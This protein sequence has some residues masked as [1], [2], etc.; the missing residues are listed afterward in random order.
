M[1]GI[2]LV[3][4][5]LDLLRPLILRNLIDVTIPSGD[6]NR[7][8][9]LT[10]G[11]LLIP[12]A[13]GWI[14]VWQR[15]LNSQVGEG[16]IYDLR[17]ALYSRLQR[18][19]LRFFTHTRV[20]ELMSRLNN[21]VI[22]A[23]NAISNT[24]VDIIT[25]IIQ[26][27]AVLAVMFALEWRLTLI[28]IVILPL[29]ILAARCSVTRLRDIAR[30]QMDA[31]AQMNAMMNETLNIG[32]AML[33]KFFGRQPTEVYRFQTAPERCADLGIDGPSWAPSFSSSSVC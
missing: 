13:T 33:V 28:S 25:E 20:G 2:I 17:V 8:L 6:L 30:K 15:R 3:K 22:G 23:Q 14:G 7:L 4:T 29:F 1:L 9:L 18:M 26:A 12:T 16:V 32:G 5:G 11:L 19:S 21:D 31:N 27:V 10:I 24:I